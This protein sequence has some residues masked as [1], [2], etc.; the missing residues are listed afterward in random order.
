MTNKRPQKLKCW[1]LSQWKLR[2][3]FIAWWKSTTNSSFV[4]LT[5]R[6]PYSGEILCFFTNKQQASRTLKR[7]QIA[8]KKKINEME[9]EKHFSAPSNARREV[10]P[11]LHLLSIRLI[12]ETTCVSHT[13]LA[14]WNKIAIA[15][16]VTLLLLLLC[17]SVV[18]LAFVVVFYSLFDLIFSQ[19]ILV[20]G[21]EK[22]KKKI[23][24][25]SI[26][27]FQMSSSFVHSE[28]NL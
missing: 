21:E 17:C 1:K 11:F 26:K 27:S 9:K 12:D 14:N 13:L 15:A 22:K 16:R 24:R 25:K 3:K 6:E 2:A 19:F 18:N 4:S 7:E 5:K 23:K 8:L 28:W 20:M 10:L